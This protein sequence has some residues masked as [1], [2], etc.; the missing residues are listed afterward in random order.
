MSN[1]LDRFLGRERTSDIDFATERLSKFRE[2]LA[3]R[4][5]KLSA[6]AKLAEEDFQAIDQL[7]SAL[8]K[9]QF[10]KITKLQETMP[11][12]YTRIS[13][14][15]PALK[16]FVNQVFLNAKEECQKVVRSYP[17]LI[18]DACLKEGVP[19]DQTST[20]PKYTFCEGFITLEI[21]E[22][23]F[24]AKAYTREGNLFV[25]PFDISLVIS[26]LK[27][28]IDRIFKHPFNPSQFAKKLYSNY[29]SIIQKE[30]KRIGDQ[31]PIRKITTRLGKNQKNFRTDEFI[32]DLSRLIEG[33][34]PSVYGYEIDL[35]HTK[36]TR[37]GILL[38]RLESH[39]YVGFI[40]FRK[41]EKT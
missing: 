26:G 32:V 5:S 24:E 1:G 25:K 28:E 11:K 16:E 8:K 14:L 37:S 9:S 22:R 41:E 13:N 7:V 17:A 4:A 38:H 31:I 18:L 19:L 35:G 10:A 12:I 3:Q 36:D 33:G 20:H 27:R 34:A 29:K 2:E 6:E 15:E 40:R 39:G 21:N 23:A 30:K